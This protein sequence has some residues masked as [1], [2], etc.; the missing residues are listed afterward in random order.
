MKPSKEERLFMVGTCLNLY[1]PFIRNELIS[2]PTF[3]NKHG[4]NLESILSVESLNTSFERSDLY[5]SARE[6]ASRDG[7]PVKVN[8]Q[9][10]DVWD[11]TLEKKSKYSYI[12]HL[13]N[14]S[15]TI[16]FEDFWPFITDIN[17]RLSIFEYE[18][19]K[20]QLPSTDVTYWSKKLETGL[21]SDDEINDLHDDLNNTPFSNTEKL[22]RE[23]ELGTS[24]LETMVPQ[25]IKYYERLIGIHKNSKNISEYAQSELKTHFKTLFQG[26]IYRG[27]ESALLM[28]S[29]STII[30]SL[31]EVELNERVL[32]KV[33]E[34]FF[35]QGD[36]TSQ[37]GLIEA[38]IALVDNYP[39]LEPQIEK[40]LIKLVDKPTDKDEQQWGLLN[41]L[42]ILVDSELALLQIFQDKP[43]FYRR[44]ASFTQAALIQR[45]VIRTNVHDNKFG[46]NTIEQRSM[47]FYCQNL[48]DL[49]LEPR[50]LPDYQT[51]QQLKSELVGR[52]YLTALQSEN[53]LNQTRIR[54]L[55]FDSNSSSPAPQLNLGINFMLPGPLEGNIS[56]ATLPQKIS[57]EFEKELFSSQL[58][59]KGVTPLINIS[60]IWM[61]DN[62]HTNHLIDI[63]K[64]AKHKLHK[65]RQQDE[66]LSILQGIAVVSAITRNTELAA[67]LVILSRRYREYLDDHS[68]VSLLGIGL[69]AAA[70]HEDIE[71]WLKYSGDW[72]SELVYLP[73]KGEAAKNLKNWLDQLTIFEPRLY[74]MCGRAIAAL[75]SAIA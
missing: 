15:K 35:T 41:A 4:L 18:C 56:A 34:N 43:T 3:R 14:Q 22:N 57:E 59:L 9:N 69:Y 21:L 73:L 40:L 25:N 74:C 39:N 47:I 26:D 8:D 11:L 24:T 63:L 36:L 38:G 23:L 46:P 12:L 16:L 31:S 48:I 54:D 62:D 28:S 29:H 60:Q 1:P 51:T 49:R 27:I 32:I 65:T 13:R 66:I 50:W 37:T 68:Q 42:I 52:I 33:F 10:Q 20:R 55:L 44:L 45:S 72:I 6:S 75:D 58:N 2:N 64:D 67:E 17:E 61:L 30:Q 5:S 53:K 71:E 70:A 19:S 7:I